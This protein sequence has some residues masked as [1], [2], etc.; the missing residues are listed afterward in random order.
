MIELF[1]NSV[2][3]DQTPR[4]VVSD[5][6]LH[7]LPVTRLG[8]SNSTITRGYWLSHTCLFTYTKDQVAYIHSR[9]VGLQARSQGEAMKPWLRHKISQFNLIFMWVSNKHCLLT[10]FFL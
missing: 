9:L 1:P 6:G 3:P 8:V 2:D 4:S 5:L 10:F 7:C